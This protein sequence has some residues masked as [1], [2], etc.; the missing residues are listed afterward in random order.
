MSD[1]VVIA[2]YDFDWDNEFSRFSEEEF[3]SLKEDDY[4][5]WHVLTC[6]DYNINPIWNYEELAKEIMPDD[7]E[8]FQDGIDCVD[9]GD[10]ID[11]ITEKTG[12]LIQE[13][14]LKDCKTESNEK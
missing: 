1:T 3:Y 14:E 9:I 6:Q 13:V 12:W 7:A 8:R 2:Y 11:L 4:E 5:Y 10:V